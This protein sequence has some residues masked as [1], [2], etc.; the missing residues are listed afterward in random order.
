MNVAVAYDY[1]D[2]ST[3]VSDALKRDPRTSKVIALRIGATPRAVENWREGLNEPRGRM[4]FKLAMEVPELRGHALRWLAAD[5]A[6]SD[7][8]PEKLAQELAQFLMSR[9]KA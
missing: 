9:S 8:S 5:N 6:E 4:F 1:D 2:Y 7:E 3:V